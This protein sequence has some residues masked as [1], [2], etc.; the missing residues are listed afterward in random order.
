MNA[1]LTS[2]RWTASLGVVVALHFAAYTALQTMHP[3]APAPPDEAILMDLAQ[4]APPAPPPPEPS[5]PAPEPAPPPEPPP[6]EPPPPEPV[7][8]PEVVV[9][10]P[11]PPP[12]PPVRKLERPVKR[13]P[14]PPVPTAPA[15]ITNLATTAAPA[16]APPV[17]TP[18]QI[19]WQGRLGA[20]LARFKRYPIAAQR[21]NEQGVVMMRLMVARDGKVISAAVVRGSGFEELD[22]AAGDW[23][24]RASPVPAFTDDMTQAQVEVTVP[25]RFSLR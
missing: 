10:E 22:Q 9:P 15:E 7:V 14:P 25:F 23:V 16:P 13:E 6:P 21:R 4:E 1:A 5:P 8:Q 12:P 24:A 17:V 18:Q 11:P 20:Y 3:L 2:A 19:S